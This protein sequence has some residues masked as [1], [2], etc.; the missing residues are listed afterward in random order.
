HDKIT[1]LH[2]RKVLWLSDADKAG[3]VNK[4]IERAS[5]YLADFFT[6]DLFPDRGDGHDIADAIID[7][8]RPELEAMAKR[9]NGEDSTPW[10][11][12]LQSS[13]VK[14]VSLCEQVQ[15]VKMNLIDATNIN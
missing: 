10:P 14:C 9:F 3:R 4:S 13:F 6:V 15:E 7:G 5:K 11:V 1:P 8:A 2:N 12:A